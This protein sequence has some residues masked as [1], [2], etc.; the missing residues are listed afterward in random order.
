MQRRPS[1]HVRQR[2]R[3][4]AVAPIPSAQQGKESG[5]LADGDE[6]AVARR[7]AL[8]G[9]IEGHESDFPD[10]RIHA[11]LPPLNDHYTE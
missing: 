2:K 10:E 3:Y 5:V 8:W 9:E 1:P 6:L 11:S 7:P 4:L